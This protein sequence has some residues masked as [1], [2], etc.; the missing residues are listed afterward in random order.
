MPVEYRL[1]QRSW[2]FNTDRLLANQFGEA[3]TI[4]FDKSY[5]GELL[6]ELVIMFQFEQAVV[7][8]CMVATPFERTAKTTVMDLVY[9]AY[10]PRR[11]LLGHL[12]GNFI[13]VLSRSMVARYVERV[14]PIDVKPVIPEGSIEAYLSY[15]E[16]EA[17]RLHRKHRDIKVVLEYHGSWSGIEEYLRIGK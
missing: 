7:R 15:L 16:Q 9:E 3:G 13:N 14:S 10:V 17:S 6:E 5:E 8:L 4:L 1:T 12:L 11:G 2:H